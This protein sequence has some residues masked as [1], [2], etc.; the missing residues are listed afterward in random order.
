MELPTTQMA[1]PFTVF[2]LAI[3]LLIENVLKGKIC[4]NQMWFGCHLAKKMPQS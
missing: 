2:S 4:L 3:F 1:N